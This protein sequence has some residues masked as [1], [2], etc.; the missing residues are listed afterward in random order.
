[1]LDWVSFSQEEFYNVVVD[2]AQYRHFVPWCTDSVVH[3]IPRESS[4]VCSV[5]EAK[6]TEISRCISHADLG[7]GFKAF[8]ETY[9]SQVIS[10]SPW[11]VQAIAHD[12]SI[13]RRLVTSWEFIPYTCIPPTTLAR[14]SQRHIMN[15]KIHA[16]YK[17]LVRFGIDFELNSVLYSQVADLFF[18]QVCKEMSHA[19]TSRCK[20][21]YGQR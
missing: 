7:I 20:Q 14:L 21:V 2:V 6:G 9:T 18:N 8:K 5:P 15:S 17:C 13:F 10:E 19:F 12:A 16:D 4:A 11:K 3:G 1:M